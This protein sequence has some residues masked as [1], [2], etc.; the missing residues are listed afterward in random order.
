MSRLRPS[1]LRFDCRSLVFTHTP[2]IVATSFSLTDWL[3]E[4]WQILHSQAEES[5]AHDTRTAGSRPGTVAAAAPAGSLPESAR[6]L[7][8]MSFAASVWSLLEK[9]VTAFTLD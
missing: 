9:E 2:R 1:S 8:H 4:S 7:P 3:G 5:G 6:V